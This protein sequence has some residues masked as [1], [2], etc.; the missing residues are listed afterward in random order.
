MIFLNSDD[1]SSNSCASSYRFPSSEDDDLYW[2]YLQFEQDK[3]P[4]SRIAEHVSMTKKDASSL[5]YFSSIQYIF[6]CN[7][8][9]KKILW[10]SVYCTITC[11]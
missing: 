2:W 8:L 9:H 5:N 10:F 7:N 3:D 6:L 4:I 11:I 1:S